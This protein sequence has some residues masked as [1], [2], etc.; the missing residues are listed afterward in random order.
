[1]TKI[2]IFLLLGLACLPGIAQQ[3]SLIRPGFF[4]AY[5]TLSREPFWWMLMMILPITCTAIWSII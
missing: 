2:I 5:A 1:M 4:R 3:D